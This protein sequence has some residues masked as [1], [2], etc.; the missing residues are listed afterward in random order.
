MLFD[1]NAF[2]AAMFESLSENIKEVIKKSP[3]YRALGQPTTSAQYTAA[4]GGSM[5][6]LDDEPPF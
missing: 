2:D 6:D 3:E 4:T 5:V 1:L